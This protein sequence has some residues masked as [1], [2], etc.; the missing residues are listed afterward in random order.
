MKLLVSGTDTEI[1]KT[2]V[3]CSLLR[4]LH[5]RGLTAVGMKP[6]CA[7]ITA[8]GTWDD[9]EHIRS[10][11]SVSA[12]LADAAPYR[13]SAPASPHFAAHEE[14]VTIQ[15]DVILAALD[16][17]ERIAE[18]VV[19]EG[20]GG[21]SGAPSPPTGQG[22]APRPRPA[23]SITPASAIRSRRSSAARMTSS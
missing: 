3:T 19:I 21:V 7:G 12:A 8:Q 11:S 6:V 2:V 16:R 13:L 23:P 14:G 15:E 10:A 20:A 18:A 17:L 1:G 22:G 4:A 9:L 5:A